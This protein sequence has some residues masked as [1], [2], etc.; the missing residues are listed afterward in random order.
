M[1]Q[2]RH[3]HYTGNKY[4]I[5]RGT[6]WYNTRAQVQ[7]VTRVELIAHHISVPEK[8]IQGKHQSNV[9]IDPTTVSSL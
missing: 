4:D 5:L 8:N 1:Q 9:V 3:S 6:H 2:R 7:R